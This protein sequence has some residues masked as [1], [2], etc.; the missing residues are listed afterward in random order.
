MNT[1]GNQELLRKAAKL[2]KRAL[3]ASEEPRF[4]GGAMG[5]VADVENVHDLGQAEPE[6]DYK[7]FVEFNETIHIE[8]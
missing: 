2:T 3:S 5:M 7:F 1:S 8:Q 6:A 4:S